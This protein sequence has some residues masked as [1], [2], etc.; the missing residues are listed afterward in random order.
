MRSPADPVRG[1]TLASVAVRNVP[2]S[3][4]DFEILRRKKP[5]IVFWHAW[6][7]AR[8]EV[9]QGVGEEIE[10]EVRRVWNANPCEPPCCPP[11]C[12]FETGDGEFVLVKFISEDF[13]KSLHTPLREFARK[14]FTL[15]RTPALHRLVRWQASGPEVPFEPGDLGVYKEHSRHALVSSGGM[16]SECQVYRWDDLSVEAQWRLKGI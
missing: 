8:R 7:Q 3:S 1:E 10:F 4:A 5:P 9:A 16:F 6:R 15:L 2:W 12:L 14:R 11:R 13:R